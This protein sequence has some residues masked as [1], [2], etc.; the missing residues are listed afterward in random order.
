MCYLECAYSK[1]IIALYWNTIYTDL[2]MLLD[3]ENPQCV[4]ISETWLT[5]NRENSL[6]PALDKYQL[7]RGDRSERSHGGVAVLICKKFA[8]KIVMSKSYDGFIEK[9]HLTA[10]LNGQKN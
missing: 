10:S 6:F 4:F 7:F 8:T 3:T 2:E 5:E 1:A 9:L